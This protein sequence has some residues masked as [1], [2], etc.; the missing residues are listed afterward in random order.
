[1]SQITVEEPKSIVEEVDKYQ[2]DCGCERIDDEEQFVV[3]EM[4]PLTDTT[5]RSQ[6]STAHIHKECAKY[7]EW[8][9]YMQTREKRESLVN[10][11]GRGLMQT[12]IYVTPFLVSLWISSTTIPVQTTLFSNGR[13]GDVFVAG[14]ESIVLSILLL[15]PLSIALAT[16]DFMTTYIPSFEK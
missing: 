7:D 4:R 6:A 1:M 10:M 8:V 15:I 11:F 12:T 9:D 14:I 5:D 3:Q 2:C 16:L 13:M